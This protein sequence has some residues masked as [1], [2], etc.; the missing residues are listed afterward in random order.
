MDHPYEK[1]LLSFRGEELDVSESAMVVDD[2]KTGELPRL[3]AVGVHFDEP[4]VHLE[5]LSRRRIVS[6]ASG[7]CG[8]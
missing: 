7:R 2:D 4:P 1:V 5:H 3:V 8:D 6:P